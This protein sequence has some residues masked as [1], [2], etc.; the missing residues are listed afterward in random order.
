[1]LLSKYSSAAAAAILLLRKKGIRVD[2]A[3]VE[4]ELGMHPGRSSLLGISEVLSTLHVANDAYQLD[5]IH[6]SEV[7]VP[8]IAHTKR[9][10][11]IVVHKIKDGAVYASSN[12]WLDRRLTDS[13]FEK[14]F[15]GY[16]LTAESSKPAGSSYLFGMPPLFASRTELA[17]W[18]TLGLLGFALAF[19]Y[20]LRPF[21]VFWLSLVLTK[22]AGL[23]IAVIL[24]MQSSGSNN[25]FIQKLC[26]SGEKT[27][28]KAIISS[29]AARIFDGLSWSEV[30][31]YYFAG[32]LLMALFPT[33]KL[34]FGSVLYLLSLA[35][36]PYTF[37]SIY[38]QAIVA[39][40]WCVFCCVVQALLWLEAI[41]HIFLN[42]FNLTALGSGNAVHLARVVVCLLVP[43]ALWQVVRPWIAG[44]MENTASKQ[45]LNLLKYNEKVFGALLTSQ[46][47][48]TMPSPSWSLLLGN[49]DAQHVIAMVS[50][51]NCNPCAEAHIHL[52]QLLQKNGN[53]QAR[54][55]FSINPSDNEMLQ[56]CRHFMAIERA[57]GE[58]T[59]K[60][61]LHDWHASRNY[62]DWA[63]KYPVIFDGNETAQLEKQF[64]WC[65]MASISGSPTFFLDGYLLPEFYRLQDLPYMLE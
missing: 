25:P 34:F 42:D 39:R 24:L 13:D 16:I 33:D 10:G 40:Q 58:A 44:A 35:S 37:Y 19:C 1:M 27:D 61:A 18:L 17:T 63:K 51:I 49:N 8:F 50:N 14:K 7:A 23:A 56:V 60:K 48:F 65:R 4:K 5:D 12:K 22:I 11:F 54:I 53:L 43:V 15:T 47:R 62:E 6:Y 28:C 32:T 57:F 26:S 46:P 45:Q 31:F 9:D 29:P 20:L 21:S 41:I 38:Y 3:S 55:I 64:D 36:L 2:A 52:E 59:I 30:G